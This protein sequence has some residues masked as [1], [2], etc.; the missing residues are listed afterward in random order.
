[1]TEGWYIHRDGQRF[2]PYPAGQLKEMAG[3]GQLLPVDLV[4]KGE[5]GAKK[6]AAQVRGLFAPTSPLPA[7]ETRPSPPR[8]RQASEPTSVPL[9]A[10][11]PGGPFADLGAKPN[12]AG[13]MKIVAGVGL[14]VIVVGL[15]CPW[16][17]M[18]SK[19][20]YDVSGMDEMTGMGGGGFGGGKFGGGGR[21]GL[22][23]GRGNEF[24]NLPKSGSMEVS[25]TTTGL[26][27]LPG[28]F[29][30][31]L[32][33]GAGVMYFLPKRLLVLLSTGLAIL[34]LF[35]ILGSFLYGP[36]VDE[37][38]SVGTKG[39]GAAA[40]AKAGSSWGQ[41]V[42][43]LGN[44]TFLAAGVLTLLGIPAAG[45]AVKKRYRQPEPEFET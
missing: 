9:P 14:A 36:S 37:A 25:G 1:M 31:L 32:T 28:V 44:L 15:L 8:P 40:S 24:G 34:L 19:G 35:V 42:S 29:A 6:P 10:S 41:F 20:S 21:G 13:W 26:L 3:N 23:G 39:F 30:F 27:S 33:V 2:G 18:S 5:D 7:P 4:S 22:G 16:Y 43:L 38:S 12:V 17:A 11:A 45:N